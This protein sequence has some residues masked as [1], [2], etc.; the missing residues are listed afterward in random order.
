MFEKP[1]IQFTKLLTKRIKLYLMIFILKNK[2]NW[3]LKMSEI[4]VK[5]FFLNF[6][7]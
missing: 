5:F 3:K 6:I 7:N 4:S 2:N 1:R